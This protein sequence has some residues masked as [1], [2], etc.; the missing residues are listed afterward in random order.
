MIVESIALHYDGIVSTH[1]DISSAF[2][3]RNMNHADL[4]LLHGVPTI[5]T[6]HMPAS[7]DLCYFCK[8]DEASNLILPI[9]CPL[10]HPASPLPA[11]PRISLETSVS[12]RNVFHLVTPDS[13]LEVYK[14]SV[15]MGMQPKDMLS[16]EAVLALTVKEPNA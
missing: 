5:R 16:G 13:I 9:P 8:A 3:S 14:R 15:S 7:S 1:G 12:K 2:V 6:A 11:F 4:A 10:S